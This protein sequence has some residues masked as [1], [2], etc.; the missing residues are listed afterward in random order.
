MTLPISLPAGITVF[1]RGW[2]SANNILFEGPHGT[3]LVDSGYAT[4]AEQTVALVAHALGPRP[5]D[6]LFNTHL[7]SDHCGGNAALQ[8]RYPALHTHIPPGEAQ[9]VAAWD[10]AALSYVATGQTCPRFGFQSLLQPGH[11]V[12]LGRQTWQVHAAKGHDPH[13]IILFSP[14]CSTLIS[15][16]AL[17]ANGFGVVFPELDGVDAFDEVAATLDLIEG[18][19]PQTLIPGHGPV[20]HDLPN[21]LAV[22]R[23]RLD[24][25][26]RDPERHL[27]Y[28]TKV[29]LKF[30]LLEWQQVSLPELEDWMQNTPFMRSNILLQGGSAEIVRQLVDSG[31]ARLQGQQI[32]NV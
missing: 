15:A 6:H 9:A 18:L 30:K 21:A 3:A 5:L 4:H 12:R 2:L 28:A 22:A 20:F 10:E 8:S 11:E 23:R 25:F 31:A 14:E 32:F 29:L 27:L 26:Q 7:H 17:W 24:G 1:E 16:D 19:A 13:S